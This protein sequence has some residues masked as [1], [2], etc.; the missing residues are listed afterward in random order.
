MIF[1]SEGNG[2]FNPSAFI[3]GDTYEVQG[4]TGTSGSANVVPSFTTQGVSPYGTYPV[5]R[6][7]TSLVPMSHPTIPH[8][9]KRTI[10]KTVLL[11]K[12]AA[13]DTNRPSHSRAWLQ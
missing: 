8:A 2:K 10:Q 6:P 12:V 9:R 13:C 4:T 11:A 7:Q 5:P 1:P 3:T